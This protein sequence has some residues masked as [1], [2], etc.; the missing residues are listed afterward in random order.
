MLFKKTDWWSVKTRLQ[1][2]VAVYW[3][4]GMGVQM[5]EKYEMGNLMLL[6][7]TFLLCKL[8]SGLFNYKLL[9]LLIP[10]KENE[11]SFQVRTTLQLTDFIFVVH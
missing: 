6:I 2:Y 4:W 7:S 8:K 11:H 5:N 3:T 10:F 9:C 1:A